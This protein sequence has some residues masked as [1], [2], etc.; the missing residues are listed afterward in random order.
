M[1]GLA[2]APAS[3]HQEQVVA[4]FR[5]SDGRVGGYPA[6]ATTSAAS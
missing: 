4:E 3:R 1:T 6:S 5:A 2:A